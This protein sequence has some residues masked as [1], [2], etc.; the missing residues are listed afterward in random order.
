MLYTTLQEVEQ[1]INKNY[2]CI[3]EVERLMPEQKQ[4]NQRLELIALIGYMYSEYVTGV[5]SSKKLEQYVYN[6]SQKIDMPI[7]NKILNGLKNLNAF[8]YTFIFSWKK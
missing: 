7:K 1:R 2:E 8:I 5:Y 3:Q 6:I 4:D